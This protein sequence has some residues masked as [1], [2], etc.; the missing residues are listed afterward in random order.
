MKLKNIFHASLVCL[1]ILGCSNSSSS[2]GPLKVD[3][4]VVNV[5]YGTPVTQDLSNGQKCVIVAEPFQGADCGLLV[6]LEKSGKTIE[7]RHQMPSALDKPA[8]FDFQNVEVTFTP[9]LSQ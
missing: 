8:I 7:S 6:K 3:M 5:K 2:S 4:G 9:H 1:L